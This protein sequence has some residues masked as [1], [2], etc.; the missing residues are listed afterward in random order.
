MLTL[1]SRDMDA[2]TLN[3]I[4]ALLKNLS[5]PANMLLRR[6]LWTLLILITPPGKAKALPNSCL[7]RLR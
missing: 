5:Y 6:A 7:G 3:P 1:Y 4:G 2:Y